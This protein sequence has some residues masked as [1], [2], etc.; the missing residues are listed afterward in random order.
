MSRASH[1]EERHIK[2]TRVSFLFFSMQIQMAL[3]LQPKR[4]GLQ[5]HGN[6]WVEGARGL[7]DLHEKQK[8]IGL[9]VSEELLNKIHIYLRFLP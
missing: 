4:G 2:E 3:L 5:R 7:S 8:K 6:F 9:M 1:E